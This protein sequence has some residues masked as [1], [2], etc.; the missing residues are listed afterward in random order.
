MKEQLNLKSFKQWRY[1][2][3]IGYEWV[4][5][6]RRHHTHT[7]PTGKQLFLGR[8]LFL[9]CPR[10]SSATCNT[11]I[12]DSQY[13]TN[14]I[15]FSWRSST[16]LLITKYDMCARRNAFLNNQSKMHFFQSW[17][18]GR[19]FWIFD[20]NVYRHQNGWSCNK[21]DRMEHN[22][23]GIEIRIKFYCEFKDRIFFVSFLSTLERSS[24]SRALIFLFWLFASLMK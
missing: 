15:N 23:Y 12:A 10:S 7:S 21:I 24:D 8:E 13:N 18:P 20:N 9:S 19:R 2:N 1:R 3:R 4:L 5:K 6:L 16:F 11:S 22:S 17:P 14:W